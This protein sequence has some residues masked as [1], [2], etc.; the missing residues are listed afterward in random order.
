MR[1]KRYLGLDVHKDSIATAVAQSG[2]N[3]EVRDTGIRLPAGEY[4]P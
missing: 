2:C 3:G 1:K 4:D